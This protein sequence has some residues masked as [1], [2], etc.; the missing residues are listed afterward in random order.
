M[1]A[2]MRS[3][4]RTEPPARANATAW[5]IAHPRPFIELVEGREQEHGVPAL[6]AYAIMQ[7]ESR[8]DP[9]VTSW[10]G[11]RGL[12]QLMPSTAE[13]EARKAGVDLSSPDRLY[14]PATNIDLGVRHLAGVAALHGEGVGAAALAVPSYNAGAGAVRRWLSERGDWDLDLFIESIPYDETRKY[15]QSVLGR[16]LAYRWIYAREA[17][18]PFLPL[19]LPKSAG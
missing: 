2:R 13:N 6:L 11:A 4:W 3:A 9:G 12:M 17:G 5:E 15:T 10:A 16:W 1:L 19:R 18:I 8:F 14:D 7:T